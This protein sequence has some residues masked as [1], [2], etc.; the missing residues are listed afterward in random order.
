VWRRQTGGLIETYR[1][2]LA[3]SIAALI[4]VVIIVALVLTFCRGE[5]ED[6]GPAPAVTTPSPTRTVAPRTA[7]AVARTATALASGTPGTPGPTSTRAPGEP[8]TAIPSL[9]TETPSLPGPPET[10][11]PGPPPEASPTPEAPEP[12]IPPGTAT[13]APPSPTFTPRPTSTP[14]PTP[15]PVKLPDLVIRDL[16]VENDRIWVR[17]GNNGKGKVPAG[18]EVEFQIRGVMEA[19]I[20]LTEDLLPG[21]TSARLLFE[22]QLIYRPERVLVVV[23]PNNLIPEEEDDGVI[24]GHN[25]GLARQLAP[26]IAPDLAVHDVSSSPDTHRLQVLIRNPTQAPLIQVTVVVTVYLGGATDP[27][28]RSTHQ[29]TIEPLGFV[30]V[31][32]IGATALPG[33]EVRVT[34]E[35]TDPPDANPANNVFEGIIP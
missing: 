29:L 1:W 28:D 33:M 24:D 18:Q 21:A 32:M 3:G 20:A 10:V 23:D 2:P 31:E 34:V 30:T 7:T 12:T 6:E 25:N 11:A 22:N 35:M 26:D 15:T 16:G 17:I 13:R 14:S 9:P 5:G 8:A 4:L 27:T 19:P